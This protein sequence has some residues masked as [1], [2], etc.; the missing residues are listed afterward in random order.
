MIEGP[1]TEN[2]LALIDALEG[3]LSAHVGTIEMILRSSPKFRMDGS[4]GT[5][6]IIRFL[7][8]GLN[9]L[10]DR[11]SCIEALKQSFET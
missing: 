3:E 5:Q 11:Q 2:E 7:N 6:K 1:M 10:K 4:D 9:I 8:Y